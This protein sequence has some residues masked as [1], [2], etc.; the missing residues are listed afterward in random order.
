[1][2]KPSN[3]R[4]GDRVLHRPSGETWVLA[5]VDGDHL[6]W[7]GWPAGEAKVSDCELVAQCSDAEH[8]KLLDALAASGGGKRARM[9]QR[10]LAAF[11][12]TDERPTDTTI[13]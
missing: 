6:A 4:A 2:R 5:Y 12:L 11:K 10:D 3:W 8:L 1:M 9:A 13:S 7:C